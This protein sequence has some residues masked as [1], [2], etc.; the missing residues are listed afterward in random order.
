[1]TNDEL[2]NL[3]QRLIAGWENEVV[4]FKRAGAD[5]DTDRIGRYFSALANEANLRSANGGWLVFGVDDSTREVVGTSYRPEHERLHGLKGQMSNGTQPSVTFRE[6]H[7]LEHDGGRVVLMEIPPAPR[8]LPISWNGHYY[9]RA[10]ESLTALGVD[11]LDAIRQQTIAKDWTAVAVPGATLAH[12]DPAAVARARLGFTGRH[13]ARIPAAEIGEWSD[14]VFLA[15]AR[16]TRNGQLTRAAVL[17]LGAAES[18]HLLSPHPAEMTWKLVGEQEAYEHFH[19]PFLLSATALAA[20]IRNVQMRLMPPNELIYREIGK[21]N[22]RSILEALYNC[23][24]HQD[25]SAR[26]RVIVIEYVDRLEFISVGEFFDGSPDDYALREATPREYRNPFLVE[27]M[28]ELN[29]IDHMGY[30]IHR[31]VQDQ[32]LRF[33]P[34]PDYDLTSRPNE[35][36]LTMPGAV[37]DQAYSQLLMVRTDLPLEDVLALDRVQKRLPISAKTAQRLRKDKLIEGRGRSVR[38]SAAV[39]AATD[40]KA[41]YIRDRAN[42]DYVAR[43]VLDFIDEFDAAT[44]ADIDSLLWDKVGDV[45]TS[46]ART[47]KISNLL[48]KLKRAGKIRNAGSRAHSSWVRAE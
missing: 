37:I 2:G 12:L 4:E 30:G 7:E 34:L 48:A 18:T 32:M 43:L 3:L 31:M 10:G 17:L 38:V 20:R 19:P 27:A 44:R 9:G 47:A 16:L 46:D 1:M 13:A 8:G 5:F 26:S 21:Y 11:K 24:A 29:L 25:Y 40:A 45:L 42:D 23:I 22:E 39:A 41:D 36:K 35:V 14:E 6:I 33:L 28:T 15:K